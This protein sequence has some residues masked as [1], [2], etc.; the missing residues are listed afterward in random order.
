MPYITREDGERFVIP[1]YRDTLAASRSSTLKRDI[2]LLS[3]NYGE[4]I[5][6]QKKGINQYEVAFS[7]ESGILLGESVW[8]YFK[9]PPEMVYC[10]VIP[11]TTEAI[12]VIVKAGSVYLDGR[13]SLDS[14]PDELVIFRTQQNNFQVYI[15]GDVPISQYEQEGKFNFDESSVQSFTV[16][17]QPVFPQLPINK[18]LQLQPVNIVLQ[19]QG[20]GVFPLKKV[21]IGVLVLGGLWLGWNILTSHEEKL[22]QPIFIPRVD[23]YLEYKKIMSSPDPGEVIRRV[24]SVVKFLYTIPG[25]LPISIDYDVGTNII[26][27]GVRSE[28]AKTNVLLAWC[29]DH[30][31]TVNIEQSG[32]FINLYSVLPTRIPSENLSSFQGAMVKLVDKLSYMVKGN[33]LQIKSIEDKELYKMATVNITF[34]SLSPLSL[35]LLGEFMQG[36][37]IAISKVSVTILNGQL[38]GTIDLQVLGN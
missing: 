14:I 33:N 10:E 17:D 4:Y 34:T 23:P 28:G 12:L 31:V 18:S 22:P 25:W 26:K 2:L 6:L 36:M 5:S 11:N 3:N 1:S 16:L 37:P 8:N 19:A 35:D 24:S 15:Y 30:H 20:I 21:L 32:I 7:S 29:I 27:A 13:F 9:R 38:S